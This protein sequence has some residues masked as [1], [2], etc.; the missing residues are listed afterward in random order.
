MPRGSLAQLMCLLLAI[1]GGMMAQ[2][3][4]RVEATATLTVSATVVG[5]IGI[6]LDENG[7]RRLIVANAP[8]DEWML[9]WIANL[10]GTD[11]RAAGPFA[12]TDTAHSALV[13]L[14]GPA[15]GKN[16]KPLSPACFLHRVKRGF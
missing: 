13:P 9:C 11:E 1:N 2:V 12:G 15:H 10:A 6:V 14:V 7:E 3:N 16:R 4:R 5:S 8:A